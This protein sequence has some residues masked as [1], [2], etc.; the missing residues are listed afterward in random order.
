MFAKITLLVGVLL[1]A[2]ADAGRLNQ[3]HLL[4]QP[5]AG[6]LI[7]PI[8][9]NPIQDTQMQAGRLCVSQFITTTSTEVLCDRY[10][11]AC[12]KTTAKTALLSPSG[13][14]LSNPAGFQ[15]SADA[16]CKV[17]GY[18]A[19]GSGSVH[20]TGANAKRTCWNGQKWVQDN[21]WTSLV[22]CK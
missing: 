1:V 8:A 16:A 9:C 20:M 22:C 5:S 21:W 15:Q 6:A 12:M 13:D 10:E 19:A 18:A 14:A 2:G 4:Q 7:P 17:L 3:R 11:P